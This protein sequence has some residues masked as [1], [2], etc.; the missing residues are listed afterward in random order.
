MD[1]TNQI[2]QPQPI[3]D[4][5]DDAGL[6]PAKKPRMPLWGKIAG[7]CVLV[8]LILVGIGVGW[9]IAALRPVDQA[10]TEARTIEIVSGTTP[11]QIGTKLKEESLIKSE[12]AFT[13]HTRIH[14]VQNSLQAG[15]YNLSSSM[16]TQ[17]V[18]A[19][20]VEGPTAREFEVTFVPGATLAENRREL[21]RVGFSEEQVDEALNATYDH[22]LF[23]SK[24]AEA[25]LEGYLFGETH[26]FVEGTSAQ[27]VLVRYF[28]DFYAFVEEHK[29]VS[30]YREQGLSLYEGITLASIIEREVSGEQDTRQVAQI[31]LKRLNE[32]IPLGADATFVYAANKDGAQ[33][34]VNYPSPYN[35]RIHAGLPPGPIAIPGEDALKAV[36]NPAAGDYVYFVSGDDGKNYYA[37]TEAEHQENIRRYCQVN[38][39]L[40]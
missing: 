1:S 10:D 32:D 24:P 35:T 27:D 37:R 14:G 25:D 39:A 38:C 40:F 23:V 19:Q 12:L 3:D 31:F 2:P 22:P 17:E 30:A 13:I 4:A 21:L 18:V 7:L 16:S 36:G 15:I 26:R 5:R 34:R 20:M 29:L 11:A 9:Y 33:P 28:D 8:L 6:S